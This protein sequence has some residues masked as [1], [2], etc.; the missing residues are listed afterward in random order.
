MTKQCRGITYSNEVNITMLLTTDKI[1]IINQI[2]S[3]ATGAK[4]RVCV[5]ISLVKVR[6]QPVYRTLSYFF[7]Y[8][9]RRTKNIIPR[10]Y[11]EVVWSDNC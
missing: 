9:K 6:G 2:A 5:F 7:Y 10:V 1:T 11:S 3:N 8:V 4:G